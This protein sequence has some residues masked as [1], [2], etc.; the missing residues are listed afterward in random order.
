MEDSAGAFAFG[1]DL[2]VAAADAKFLPV[3]LEADFVGLD[4]YEAAV[5]QFAFELG[6]AVGGLPLDSSLRIFGAVWGH[7]VGPDEGQE[8]DDEGG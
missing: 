7:L 8:G 5:G 2:A 4:F 3:L 6:E 1:V